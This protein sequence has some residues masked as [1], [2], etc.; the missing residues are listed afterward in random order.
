MT[1]FLRVF[2]LPSL[3]YEIAQLSDHIDLVSYFQLANLSFQ[4]GQNTDYLSA[5]WHC[6]D[7]RSVSTQWSVNPEKCNNVFGRR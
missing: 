7:A 5:S 1:L 4:L 3:K 2:V 6:R